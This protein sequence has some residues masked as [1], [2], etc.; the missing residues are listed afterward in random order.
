MQ[1]FIPDQFGDEGL[2]HR[3]IE[4]CGAA[5]QEGED[6]HVPELDD[7]GDGKRPQCQSESAH[8][9]LCGDQ[10]LTLIEIVGGEAGPGQE[11][12]LWP[13]LQRHD[14]ADGRGVVMGELGEHQPVLGRPLDPGADIGDEGAAD[15]D[16]IV[17]ASQR[18][19]DTRQGSLH[20]CSG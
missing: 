19:E 11:K 14:Q 15:P 17:E 13:E 16:P 5:E 10:Q 6:V 2:A 20:G 8:R 1:V 4:R 7:A 18:P 3:R 9:R 12:E